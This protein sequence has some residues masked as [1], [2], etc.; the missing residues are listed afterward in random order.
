MPPPT[1]STAPARPAVGALSQDSWSQERSKS[2][3]IFKSFFDLI[4]DPFGVRFGSLLGSLLASKSTQDPS[5]MHF[6]ALSSSKT[7]CS[8]NPYKTNEI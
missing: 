2:D 8:R 7:R 6:Q 5:K 1:P 4:L 3:V